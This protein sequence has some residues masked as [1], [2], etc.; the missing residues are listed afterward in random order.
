MLLNRYLLSAFMGDFSLLQAAPKQP[1]YG[2]PLLIVL[3]I[4]VMYFFM[5]RPQQKRQREQRRFVGAIKEGDWIVTSGGLHGKIASLEE[6]GVLLLDV[7]KGAK[8]K[9]DRSAISYDLSKRYH[10]VKK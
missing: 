1:W 9:L 7:G 3:M 8:L 6:E 4:F 10:S 2:T 5:L